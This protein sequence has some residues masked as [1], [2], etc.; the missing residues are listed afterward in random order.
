MPGSARN[1]AI[2]VRVTGSA[3]DGRVPAAGHRRGEV[4][5]CGLWEAAGRGGRV[6][7]S[8]PRIHLNLETG[9]IWGTVEESGTQHTAHRLLRIDAT[10][11][12]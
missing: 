6:I 9:F 10:H 8:L 2:D 12:A 5:A 7:F 4:P 3:G 1:V 11:F